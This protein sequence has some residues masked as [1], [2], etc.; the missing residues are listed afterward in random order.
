[1]DVGLELLVDVGLIVAEL[2]DESGQSL[3]HSGLVQVLV[4]GARTH[5]QSQLVLLGLVVQIRVGLDVQLDCHELEHLG[6]TYLIVLVLIGCRDELIVVVDDGDD[7]NI[8]L[9]CT[10]D[11]GLS[12]CLL[13]LQLPALLRILYGRGGG[14]ITGTLPRS[15][16]MITGQKRSS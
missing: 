5:H 11:D 4:D 3:R 6:H 13:H 12:E 16:G 15:V 9:F 1:M 2:G 7:S 8:S 10:Y 14:R